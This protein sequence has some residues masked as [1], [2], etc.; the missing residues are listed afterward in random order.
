MRLISKENP[1]W[2]AFGIIGIV[3]LGVFI[4]H[5]TNN[6]NPERLNLIF[7]TVDTLRAD[8]LSSYGYRKIQTPSID[9]ITVKGILFKNAISQSPWTLPSFASFFSSLYPSAHGGGKLLTDGKKTAIR[10]DVPLLAEILKGHG[11]RTQAFVMN[12]Y[13]HRAWGFARGFEGYFHIDEYEAG[14]ELTP[15]QR[16]ATPPK[17]NDKGKCKSEVITQRA[18]QWLNE[19]RS[20]NFFL[21]VHYLDPHGPFERCKS[22]GLTKNYK[23]ALQNLVGLIDADRVRSGEF[24]LEGEDKEY[25]HSLYDEEVMLTDEYIGVLLSKIRELGL[26]KKSIIVFTSD[27]GEEFWGH[28]DYGHGHSVYNEVLHVPLIIKEPGRSLPLVVEEYVRLIDVMPTVLEML[29]I[30]FQYEIHG[31]SLMSL[32]QKKPYIPR[33]IFSEYLLYVYGEEKKGLIRFPYKFIY[34]PKSGKQELYDL[35]LDPKEKRNLV[36]ANPRVA[37]EMHSRMDSLM[38]HLVKDRSKPSDGIEIDKE[39]GER[40]KALG[41]VN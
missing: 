16:A 13:V 3:V 37:G 2:L 28:G 15:R 14:K 4:Y 23:G 29:S 41:Y 18:T 35:S 8:H 1:F 32:I 24:K 27:H 36:D 10:A 30:E 21:W 38:M 17:N 39:T 6:L 5:I 33:E 19:H 40:L 7:I 20:N 34:F 31:E 11:Y 26:D 9:S 22:Y 25:I 12:G